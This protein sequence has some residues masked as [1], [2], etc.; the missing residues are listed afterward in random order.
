MPASSKRRSKTIVPRFTR[1]GEAPSFNSI[2]GSPVRLSLTLTSQL[3]D[4]IPD[5]IVPHHRAVRRHDGTAESHGAVQVSIG[6]AP[7]ERVVI[8]I[9]I[10]TDHIMINIMMSSTHRILL[11]IGINEVIL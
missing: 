2:C 9:L 6:P 1:H 4:Q 8:G 3:I 10:L 11:I 7:D 5:L